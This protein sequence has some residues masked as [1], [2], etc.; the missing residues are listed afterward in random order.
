MGSFCIRSIREH[1]QVVCIQ[2]LG[3]LPKNLPSRSQRDLASAAVDQKNA[4]L[5]FQSDDLFG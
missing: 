5:A 3:V 2:G 4:Q 1:D